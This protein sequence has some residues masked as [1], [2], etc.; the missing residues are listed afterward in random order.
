MD[1]TAVVNPVGHNFISS[2]G[3]ML[4]G[5]GE[6][7]PTSWQGLPLRSSCCCL[8]PI[9]EKRPWPL[10]SVVTSPI[11]SNRYGRQK[12]QPYGAEIDDWLHEVRF[13]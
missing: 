1:S 5:A 7:R 3:A 8:L 12:T 2:L 10:S 4:A 13:T 6:G 11:V 9:R